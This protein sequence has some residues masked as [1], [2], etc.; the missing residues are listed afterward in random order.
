LEQSWQRTSRTLR[1]RDEENVNLKHELRRCP[2]CEE[3]VTRAQYV[4]TIRPKVAEHLRDEHGAR[5][6]LRAITM[7]A[8]EAS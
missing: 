2:I 1:Q 6:R 5:A 4:E 8:G 7:K 3:I